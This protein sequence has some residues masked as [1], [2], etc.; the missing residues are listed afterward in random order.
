MAGEPIGFIDM[1]VNGGDIANRM[2]GGVQSAAE[3]WRQFS[4]AWLSEPLAYTS[5][6][7]ATP[8][9]ILAGNHDIS[10]AIGYTKPLSP[11][12]D[13]T[14]AAE[15]YNH[16]LHPQKPL[17]P[18]TFDY[19]RH[20]VLT[21]ID[22]KGIKFAFCGMWLDTP[23]RQWLSTQL[24]DSLPAIVFTHDEPYVETK[25]LTNPHGNH[26]IQARYG[27]ENLVDEISSVPS[28]N[29]DAATEHRALEYYV[30]SHP[31]VKAWFH[32]NT[33]YNEFYTWT[34]PDGTATLPVFRV[35]SPMKGEYSSTDETLLSF[36]V[37]VIDTDNMLMT[38]RE[39]LWNTGNSPIEWGD[40]ITVSLK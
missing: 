37:A 1:I 35:D 16:T 15:I 24:C 4:S 21:A 9:Y 18:D 26:R 36:I 2:E 11:V 20:K 40:S 12:R 30:N 6:G 32:G 38:V 14:C 39:C 34:G 23:T 8:V 3:S 22:I 19:A 25:H 29:Q 13:A 33:N 28:I 31:L 17:T 10:N 7:T 27:F 5:Y